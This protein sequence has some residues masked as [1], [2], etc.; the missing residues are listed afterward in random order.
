MSHAGKYIALLRLLVLTRTRF[1]CVIDFPPLTIPPLLAPVITSVIDGTTQTITP[2]AIQSPVVTVSPITITAA[3]A[4][5]G[6][7]TSLPTA[8]TFS[9]SAITYPPFMYTDPS[10]NQQQNI[11]GVL[12]PL[13]LKYPPNTHGGGGGSNSGCWFLCNWPV[14]M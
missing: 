7:L 2:P 4:V 11:T 5:T 13:P 14:S 12:I 9:Q 6:A 10:N 1:P 3:P 8:V